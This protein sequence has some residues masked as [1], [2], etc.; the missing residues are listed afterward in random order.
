MTKC[1]KCKGQGMLGGTGD[2]HDDD[3]PCTM[4]VCSECNGTGEIK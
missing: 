1:T 2:F 4:I 3:L